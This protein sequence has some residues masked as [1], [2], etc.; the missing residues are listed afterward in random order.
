MGRTKLNISVDEMKDR[1]AAQKKAYRAKM[2]AKDPETYK[3]WQAY[4]KWFY[5]L[6]HESY[7]TREAQ[8]KK[9]ARQAQIS[10][11]VPSPPPKL[12]KKEHKALMRKI[13]RD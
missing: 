11:I 12:S 13:F 6:H 1:R 4:V 3:D 9:N 8:K 10:P 2:R 5:R 7:R